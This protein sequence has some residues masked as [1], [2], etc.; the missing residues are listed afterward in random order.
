MSKQ[1]KVDGLDLELS[2]DEMTCIHLALENLINTL[3]PFQDLVPASRYREL[4]DLYDKLDRGI[5]MF[6]GSRFKSH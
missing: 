5:A 1:D 4:T 2:Y 3:E 6:E